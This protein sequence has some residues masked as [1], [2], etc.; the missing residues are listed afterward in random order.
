MFTNSTATKSMRTLKG[1][2][3]ANE[4]LKLQLNMDFF[5]RQDIDKL[6]FAAVTLKRNALV[7]QQLLVITT[8]LLP[9]VI[10]QM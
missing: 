2:A 10:A 3:D 7:L 6:M 8:R 5:Y 4:V 9:N 1:H